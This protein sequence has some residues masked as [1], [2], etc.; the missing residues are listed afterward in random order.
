MNRSRALV[1]AGILGL[2]ACQDSLEPVAPRPAPQ[3]PL[4]AQRAEARSIPGRYIV[5]FRNDVPN[6]SDLATALARAYGGTVQYTYGAAIKGF[7]AALPEQAVAALAANPNVAFVEQDQVAR[8]VETQSN[9]TWG[10]DRIDQRALPLNTSYTYNFTGAGVSAYIV[11]TG[12][13]TDH[14][15]FGGPGG[16]ASIGFDAIGDG[17]NG[18]DCNGHGT[19]VAG[20]VGGTIY[21]VAKGVSLVAVRVLNCSGSGTYSGVIAGVDWVTANHVKPAV[22]NM[23]LGGGVSAALNQAVRSSIAAGVVYAVAAG[24]ETTDACNRSPASTGEAI[25]VAATTQTDA[26]ASFSNFGSCVDWFAPGVG[27]T[28]AWHTTATATNTISGTSMATPHTA[29]V[30][31]LYFQNHPDAS[32][33]AVRDGLFALTTKGIVTNAF[34]ANN[35]LL[36]SLEEGGGEPP[37]NSP[38]TSSFTYSCTGLTC[39]FTDQSTDSD[40]TISSRSWTFG[41]GGTSNAENPSYTYAASGTYTVTLTVTDDDGATDSFS[42]EV[43]VSDGSQVITLTAT[44][45]KV[46]GLQKVDLSWSGAT[47][48]NVDVWRNGVKITTTPNDGFHTDNLNS[49]GSGTYTYRVCAAGTTTCSN[50]ATVTF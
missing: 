28:S 23:S 19:H 46:K 11:D 1:A 18:N 26:R 22:A 50:D 8:I 48:V 37:P 9:A 7:A 38:P 42:Q 27:I 35:H 33:Q 16:R 20:T 2:T 10:L 24:N 6:P 30:A 36:Y 15:E 44:G 29:G 4:M 49:R 14:V 17:Q 39:Q 45:Y 31:A 40:G 5:V 32:A 43:T 41:D 25:T 47:S 3:L 21:G 13:R 12:I 34:T